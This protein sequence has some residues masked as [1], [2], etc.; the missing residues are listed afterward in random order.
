MATVW[1]SLSWDRPK[2]KIFQPFACIPRERINH[3]QAHMHSNLEARLKVYPL[4]T[5][6]FDNRTYGWINSDLTPLETDA[7]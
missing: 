6:H 4:V 3:T 2:T 1:R 7:Q 5:V